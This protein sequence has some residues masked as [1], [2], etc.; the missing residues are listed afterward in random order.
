MS[1]TIENQ[2]L[3]TSVRIEPQIPLHKRVKKIQKALGLKEDR[4]LN[5]QE[6]YLRIIEVGTK[7]ICKELNIAA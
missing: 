6:T 4:D 5:V 3:T 2:T 1:E 7:I